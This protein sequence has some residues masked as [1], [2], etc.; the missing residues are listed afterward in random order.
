[1]DEEKRDDKIKVVLLEP[2]KLARVTE[3]GTELEDLQAVVDGMIEAA[4]YFPEP[5]CLVCNDEGKIN[6]MPLN[7]GVRDREGKLI[8]IIAGPAFIC[9]CS[10]ENF[11]SLNDNQLKKY[12]E[13]FKYPEHFFKVNDEIQGVKYNPNRSRER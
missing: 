3:I 12:A 5:V 4:Y 9:D 7:R 6:G 1:M 10:G 13:E 8:D 11:G 2:G